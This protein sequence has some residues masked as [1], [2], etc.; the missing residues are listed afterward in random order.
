MNLF[1]LLAVIYYMPESYHGQSVS[2]FKTILHNLES[3][4]VHRISVKHSRAQETHMFLN[5]E[6]L[7][8]NELGA[9][10]LEI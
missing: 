7:E 5:L 2:H 3:P 4:A 9:A 8:A 1:Y 6:F 10:G